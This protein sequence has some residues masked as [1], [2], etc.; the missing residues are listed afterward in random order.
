MLFDQARW[1]EVKSGCVN[2]LIVQ[3]LSYVG[4]PL[5]TLYPMD[6]FFDIN[7]HLNSAARTLYTRQLIE[8]VKPEFDRC[9]APLG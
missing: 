7:Y 9:K 3:G 6:R 8:L 1:E 5:D 4:S 2:W